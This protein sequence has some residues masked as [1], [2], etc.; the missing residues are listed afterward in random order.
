MNKKKTFD[1]TIGL[2]VS[3]I[4]FLRA[5]ATFF[6]IFRLSLRPSAMLEAAELVDGEG[7]GTPFSGA[8][9]CSTLA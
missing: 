7:G 2:L 9:V 3:N 6:P 4:N 8:A 5:S 1:I